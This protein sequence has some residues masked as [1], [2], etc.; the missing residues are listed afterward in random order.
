LHCGDD[1]DHQIHRVERFEIVAPYTLT[2]Q[3]DDGTEQLID[4][5]P[6]L[7]C[8]V[9][10]PSQDLQLFNAVELDSFGPIQWPNGADFDPETLHRAGQALVL[11]HQG[12][13]EQWANPQMEPTRR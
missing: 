11:S 10:G 2:P 3:F 6:V 7:E 4:F 9:F 12:L 13:N 8:E 1:I 5:R